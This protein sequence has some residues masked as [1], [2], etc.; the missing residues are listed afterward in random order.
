MRFWIY[1]KGDNNGE[2]LVGY[3]YSPD[4]EITNL[5]FSNYQSC[6][7]NSTQCSWQRIDVAL[8]PILTQITE[9]IT[10]KREFFL[11]HN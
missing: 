1:F 9:V 11:L 4:S 5:S 8:S 2:L 3:R 7:T 6:Q 10:Q